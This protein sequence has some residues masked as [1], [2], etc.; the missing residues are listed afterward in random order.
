MPAPACVSREGE[1]EPGWCGV[2]GLPLGRPVR[3][4]EREGYSGDF[5]RRAGRSCGLTRL[6]D[7][8]VG[9]LTWSREER[10]RALGVG[11]GWARHRSQ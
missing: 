8:S 10:E 5:P 2:T 7:F 3:F 6:G 4:T 11:L 1:R 9:V